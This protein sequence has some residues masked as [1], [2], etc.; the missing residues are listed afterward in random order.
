M[1]IITPGKAAFMQLEKQH[2][3]NVNKND[4]MSLKKGW[5]LLMHIGCFVFVLTVDCSGRTNRDPCIL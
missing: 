4:T 5:I 1:N 3:S 2:I